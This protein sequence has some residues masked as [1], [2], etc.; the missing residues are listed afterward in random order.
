MNADVVVVGLG[1]MGSAALQH[2]AERGLAVVGVD[3]HDVPNSEGSSHGA[4]RIIRTAYFEDPRYVPLVRR[5]YALWQQLEQ[6]VRETLLTRTGGVHLAAADHPCIAGVERAAREHA[7]PYERLDDAALRARFPMFAIDDGDVGI[8]EADTGVL[9]PERCVAAQVIAAVRAG[10]TVR[11]R[12]RVT[13]IEPSAAGVVVTTERER[14]DCGRVVIATGAWLGAVDS[15]LRIDVPIVVERQVQ[16]WF[17][18]RRP[19]LFDVG[20]MPAFVRA[21]GDELYYGVPRVDHPG[22]KV[23]RH[24]GGEHTTA[25][26]LAR[27]PTRDDEQQVRAFLRRRLPE[28]DGPLVAARVCMYANSPDGHFVV[29]RHPRHERVLVAGGFSGHGFKFAPVIGEILADLATNGA[30]DHAIDLFDP[31]RREV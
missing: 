30:T 11:G 4:S 31:A 1:A 24:H 29:G 17:Q 27:A 28:A 14:I 7:L 8:Y 22:V 10:A 18:P 13:A 15:P 2:L 5:A 21:D 6:G 20:A 23:C 3:Q 12:E 9:A 19:A 26:D 16:C 25:A